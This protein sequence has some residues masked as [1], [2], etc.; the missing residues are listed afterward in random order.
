MSSQLLQ[1]QFTKL[2]LTDKEEGDQHQD[3]ITIWKQKLAWLTDKEARSHQGPRVVMTELPMSSWTIMQVG[4]GLRKC[5]QET[6]SRGKSQPNFKTD[7]R[8]R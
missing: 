4:S 7:K 2:L 8:V 1:V 5:L 3:E 6:N